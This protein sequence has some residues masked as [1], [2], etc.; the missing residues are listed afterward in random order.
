MDRVVEHCI[1]LVE[2]EKSQPSAEAAGPAVATH[3]RVGGV[4]LMCAAM[5]GT[6]PVEEVVR[7]LVAL[8]GGEDG[9]TFVLEDPMRRTNDKSTMVTMHRFGAVP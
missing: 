7:L 4:E 3:V 6:A 1:G 9:N 5:S 2:Q 8:A